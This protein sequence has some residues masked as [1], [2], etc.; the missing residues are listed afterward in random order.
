MATACGFVWTVISGLAAI[1]LHSSALGFFTVFLGAFFVFYYFWLRIELGRSYVA[2]HMS[3]Y[4]GLPAP[5]PGLECELGSN[6]EK[7]LFRVNR[8]DREGAFIFSQKPAELESLSDQN[9]LIFVFRN[10]RIRCSGQAVSALVRGSKR[11]GYGLQFK[12]MSADA[13]K[14]LG[15]FI[16]TLKGEGYVS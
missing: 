16:E 9:E 5:L 14:I 10:K 2:P 1:R 12:G 15:D 6:T 11:R 4:Q 7:T 13:R 8:I 3:W